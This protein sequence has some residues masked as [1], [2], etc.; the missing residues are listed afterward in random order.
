MASITEVHCKLRA[1]T[2]KRCL[3]VFTSSLL[4]GSLVMHKCHLLLRHNAPAINDL[5]RRRRWHKI[6]T[7][8]NRKP[9][10]RHRS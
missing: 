5:C 8:T 3:N 4:A 7:S 1:E 9:K 10:S 2:W 6:T